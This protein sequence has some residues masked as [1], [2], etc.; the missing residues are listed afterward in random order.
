MCAQCCIRSLCMC[1]CGGGHV[2]HTECMWRLENIPVE[3]V[4]SCY[5]F[6]ESSGL[7]GKHL[8]PSKPL[9]HPYMD[10][11]C[12]YNLKT[13][14]S[15]STSYSASRTINF[16]TPRRHEGGLQDKL[17]DIPLKSCLFFCHLRSQGYSDRSSLLALQPLL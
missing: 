17:S 1:V 8:P 6:H 13:F 7:H 11:F 15:L 4:L 2:C 12:N 9:H 3:S 16:K 5:G 14:V 10:Y